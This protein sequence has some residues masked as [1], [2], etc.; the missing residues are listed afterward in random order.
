MSL[1]R[2]VINYEEIQPIIREVFEDV[3]LTFS[4]DVDLSKVTSINLD[5]VLIEQLLD[6]YGVT[7]FNKIVDNEL[8]RLK[9]DNYIHELLEKYT[10]EL[11]KYSGEY[12][13]L[14]KKMSKN[15]ANM[16]VYL[17]EILAHLLYT[18]EYEHK[19]K[20]YY[21][22]VPPI[23]GEHLVTQIF[24]KDVKVAGLSF[25]QIGYKLGDALSLIINGKPIMTR[26]NFKEIGERIMLQTPYRVFKNTEIKIVFHNDSGNH[27]HFWVDLE[28]QEKTNR[29]PPVVIPPIEE[30]EE[31]ASL[32]NIANEW[33]TAITMRWE[34]SSDVDMDLH[35]TIDNERI[36]FANKEY[37]VDEQNFAYLNFDFM[38]HTESDDKAKK[39]EII[40]IN[41]FKGK[42]AIVEV[43]K[44]NIASVLTEDVT[45]EISQKDNLGNIKPIG[46]HTISKDILNT[47][48]YTGTNRYHVTT[49]TL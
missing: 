42:Q 37:K 10:A 30:E 1:P 33:N 6:E 28:Y 11:R 15:Y 8:Q 40:T 14:Y 23:R 21:L 44:Y 45:I 38:N 4:I 13:K 20:G 25:N 29:L 46:S 27:H 47:N 7:K 9:I 26:V 12:R 31:D 43:L 22:E 3:V 48:E 16:R 18:E 36:Y 49:I 19:T 35:V 34:G 2:Y 39:P 41:N 5:T 24:D 17:S 32:G